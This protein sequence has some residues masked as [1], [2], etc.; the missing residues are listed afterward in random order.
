MRL[1]EVGRGWQRLAECTNG[2]TR[3]REKLRTLHVTWGANCLMTNAPRLWYS[4]GCDLLN[5]IYSN[6]FKYY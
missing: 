4:G 5:K 2:L 6:I 1:A 3:E